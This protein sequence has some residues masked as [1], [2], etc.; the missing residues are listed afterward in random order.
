MGHSNQTFTSSLAADSLRAQPNAD[1]H[2]GSSYHSSSSSST[3]A[4]DII[5]WY[6]LRV[7]D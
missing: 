1:N 4:H 2:K 6:I 5:I 3:V 7:P